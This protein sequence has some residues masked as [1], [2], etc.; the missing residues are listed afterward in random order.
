MTQKNSRHGKKKTIVRRLNKAALD[1]AVLTRHWGVFMR[2]SSVG[3]RN[4]IGIVQGPLPFFLRV[5]KT[6]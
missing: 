1:H 2:L 6:V 4:V 5:S 3:A